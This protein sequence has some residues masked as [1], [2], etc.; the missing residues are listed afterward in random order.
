MP[1]YKVRD[2]SPSTR[3]DFPQM[4]RLLLLGALAAVVTV[5]AASASPAA[6]H[7]LRGT[8]VAKDRAHRALVVA[9]SGGRVQTLVASAAFGRTDIGRKV[10]IRYSSL[11]GQLPVALGVS[12]KGHARHAV[13][14][15]TIVR[16][17]KRHA[18]INAGGSVLNVTLRA[19]K[20]QRALAS[21]KDTPRAGDLVT[22]EVDIDD[23][24]SLAASAVGVAVAPVGTAA[25]SEGE[26][27]VRGKVKGPLSAASITVTTGTGFDVTCVI[28]AGLTLNVKVDDAI[29][30]KCDFIAGQWT[31]R[32]ARGEDDNSDSAGDDEAKVEVRGTITALTLA[33]GPA[34]A[35]VTVTPTEGAA[36]VCAIPVGISLAQFK[37]NDVVKMECVKIGDL[38]TLKEIE[39]KDGD[40]GEQSGGGNDN[41]SS[42]NSD[43]ESG[44]GGSDD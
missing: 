22:V 32:V 11:I 43:G 21:A 24:G 8:V 2:H 40:S 20:G 15:G 34:A 4:K 6:T 25:G 44:S 10:V 13:V 33:A 3:K 29:E 36:V 30:L 23:D 7:T 12:L 5:P 17:V 1:S 19:P 31:V 18:I 41:N 35:T 37:V 38:L 14:R 16:L 27:E 39:I 28:P 42:G 26:M 9:V